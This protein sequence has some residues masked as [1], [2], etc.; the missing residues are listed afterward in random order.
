M[1]N[2]YTMTLHIGRRTE[3]G[4][5]DRFELTAQVK[6]N[7]PYKVHNAMIGILDE[8]V[9]ERTGLDLILEINGVFIPN[10]FNDKGYTVE[11]A[12]KYAS[13]F[14]MDSFFD[15]LKDALTGE[16]SND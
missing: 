5:K 15:M 4:F 1:N 11:E 2:K 8:R 12:Y 9:I 7:K 10:D 3:T 6:G 16:Y 14:F 13:E